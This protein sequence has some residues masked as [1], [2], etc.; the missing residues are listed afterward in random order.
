MHALS[1]LQWLPR[2]NRILK[3]LNLKFLI[4]AQ[5]PELLCKI[6]ASSG[7]HAIHVNSLPLGD[8]TPDTQITEFSDKNGFTV[9]TKDLDFY[10]G[11]KLYGKPEKLLLITTGNMKNRDLFN[12]FRNNL[13]TIENLAQHSDYLEISEEG[14]FAG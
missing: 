4:D 1:M 14:V 2:I 11:H 6:L 9:I 5:L 13:K 3:C 10:H 8:E 7:I 12:M